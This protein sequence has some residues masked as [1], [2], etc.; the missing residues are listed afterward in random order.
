[1]EYFSLSQ[2]TWDYLRKGN[3]KALNRTSPSPIRVPELGEDIPVPEEEE[4]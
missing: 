3:A 2:E 4:E 1:M